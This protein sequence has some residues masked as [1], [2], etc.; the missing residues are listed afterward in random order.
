MEG[1]WVRRGSHTRRL[2]DG[3][4][5]VVR[6]YWVLQRLST[7][8]KRQRFRHQCPVCGLEVDTVRMPNGGSVHFEKGDGLSRVKHPCLYLGERLSRKR[9]ESTGDLFDKE[10]ENF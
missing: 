7:D 6:A 9:D 8:N 1:R 4:T 3:K 2:P 5:T 10:A